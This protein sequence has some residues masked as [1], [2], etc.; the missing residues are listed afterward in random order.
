M[1]AK[2]QVGFYLTEPNIPRKLPGQPYNEYTRWIE[3][4]LAIKVAFGREEGYFPIV[5]PVSSKFEYD[6]GRG[7]G[8]PKVLVEG[9]LESEN[10]VHTIRTTVAGKKA[11]TLRW[12]S[13]PAPVGDEAQAWA[14]Y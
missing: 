9:A 12:R 2:P 6:L 7:A 5:M 14:H 11:M 10:G 1:P 3:G 4:P 13:G 8:L